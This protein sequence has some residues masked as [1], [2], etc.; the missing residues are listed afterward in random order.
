MGGGGAFVL[1][2]RNGTILSTAFEASVLEQLIRKALGLEHRRG[3]FILKCPLPCLVFNLCDSRQ[4]LVSS[5]SIM[6]VTSDMVTFPSP[7]TSAQISQTSPPL[8][9]ASIK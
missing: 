1:V 7:S 5:M 2:D 6:K 4:L 8:N 3:H 9:S